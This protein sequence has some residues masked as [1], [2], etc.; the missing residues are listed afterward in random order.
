MKKLL[1]FALLAVLV[2]G[3]T[4][5]MSAQKFGYVNSAKILSELP[6]MKAAESNLDALR[7]QLQKKGQTMLEKLQADYAAIQQKIERGELSP[8]MQQQ[9][10]EKL[11][12]RQEEIAQFEQ[13]MISDLQNKRASLM[14]PILKKVNDAIAAVA[15]EGGYLFIF[16]KQVLLYGQDSAD[17]SSAVRAK[18]NL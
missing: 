17:V 3:T 6:D 18:L 14:E 4:A 13:Q 11:Q 2:F 8:A 5:T 9:E 1:Q 12:A 16:D 10:G 15:K 7:Q